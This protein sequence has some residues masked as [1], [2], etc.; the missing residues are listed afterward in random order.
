VS[1]DSIQMPHPRDLAS[2]C[3]AYLAGR[4][5]TYPMRCERFDTAI[6]TM[7][8]HGLTDDDIVLDFGAGS[9]DL[10]CRLH[11]HGWHGRYWPVDGWMGYDLNWWT[12]K[13]QVT[14]VVA[15]EVIEHL[16]MFIALQVL[17]AFKLWATKG[18][19]VT[20]PNPGVV[21]VLGIDPTHR[22]ACHPLDLTSH[23]YSVELVSHFGKPE[24][25]LVGRWLR[26]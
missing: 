17:D 22:W 5:A 10:A 26:V 13:R 2:Q 12:P 11:E 19:I 1:T 14:W 18:V 23:G 6:A 4:T 24:D 16:P 7:R 21:D 15:L 25:S 20:T 9:T 8:S 3:D